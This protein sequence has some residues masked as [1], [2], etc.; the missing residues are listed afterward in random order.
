MSIRL[1]MFFLVGLPFLA[2]VGLGGLVIYSYGQVEE[3]IVELNSLQQQQVEVAN[4]VIAAQ[5]AHQGA[6]QSV[7]IIDSS[8]LER[9]HEQVKKRSA[10]SIETFKSVG[11]SGI[12]GFEEL[13]E[14]WVFELERGLRSN[15]SVV[16]QNGERDKALQAALAS[17]DTMRDEIDLLGELVNTALD[18]PTLTVQ[19]RRELE[20]ALS[21]V[22]NADRDAYQ[23]YVAQ[24]KL[25]RTLEP[26][27][28]A[29]LKDG[30]DEN[31]QQTFDRVHEGS[32][33]AGPVAD[34]IWVRFEK[35]YTTWYEASATAANL[36]LANA[37]ENFIVVESF[38]KAEERFNDLAPKIAALV[39]KTDTSIVQKTREVNG[40]LSDLK[41]LITV[42]VLCFAFFT[43]GFGTYLGGRISKSVG[44]LAK[45]AAQLSDGD[46]GVQ[47]TSR[48]KDEIGVMAQALQGMVG[49][50]GSTIA[51]V[52]LV[53]VSVAAGSGE[54]SST[55]QSLS[56]GAS[57]QSES[58][59]RVGESLHSM[60][61][62]VS[63]SSSTAQSTA[64]LIR[65]ASQ[66]AEQSGMAV[67]DAVTSMR[68]IAEQ[69]HVIEEIARQTDL[70]AL[71]AAIEAARAGEHGR[72]FAVVASEVRALAESSAKAA[73]EIVEKSEKTVELSQNAGQ[74]LAETIPEIQRS[75]TMIGELAA[76]SNEQASVAQGVS[77]E[78]QDLELIIQQ[79]AAAAEELAATA[80]E[81]Q[82][83]SYTLNEAI[84]FFKNVDLNDA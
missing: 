6:I 51:K 77:Q 84:G 44:S 12:T 21:L 48:S 22:L 11:A 49:K 82:G 3:A 37:S 68:Q 63:S 1:K 24:L 74:T 41:L 25:E 28:L 50:V 33:I 29:G 13:H 27:Q 2:L 26:E 57:N 19:R 9:T 70:L 61:N 16:L 79:N 55:A 45:G 38:K 40:D 5:Q 60:V 65:T 78:M 53:S 66:K 75:A 52:K 36:S 42:A 34:E 14:A 20:S 83:Q 73:R 72:G 46:F 32:K 17:F 10:A 39:E 7:Q 71:N 47:F 31:A 15:K 58:V 23:A 59:A 18:E 62:S 30:F 64:A 54:L 69:I 80:E 76:S 8:E 81:L 67:A 35:A 56:N 4:A 43:F